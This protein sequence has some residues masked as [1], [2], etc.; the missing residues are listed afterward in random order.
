MRI[1]EFFIFADG[2]LR[3]DLGLRALWSLLADFMDRLAR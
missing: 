2:A 1:G 3:Q